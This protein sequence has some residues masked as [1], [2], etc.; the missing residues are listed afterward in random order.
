MAQAQQQTAQQIRQRPRQDVAGYT[1]IEMLIAMVIIVLLGTYVGPTFLDA[2]N[3]NRQQAAL[4]DIF[5]MLGTARSEAVTRRVSVAACASP[6]GDACSGSNWESGWIVFADDG[7]GG[8]TPDDG[9]RQAGEE[10]IRI[11]QET[12][13]GVTVR[14]RNFT[15]AGVVSFDLNGMA[16]ERGTFVICRDDPQQA[17]GIVLNRSGQPRVAV[18]EDTPE[19]RMIEADDGSEVNTCP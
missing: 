15:T 12:G 5:A 18:D 14:T 11:G 17:S 10:L 16:A 1:L 9:A 19:N 7:N 4:G 6:D 2:V 13:G 8:G 3:R